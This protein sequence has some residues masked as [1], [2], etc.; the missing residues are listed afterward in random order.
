MARAVVSLTMET[1]PARQ[2]E[3]CEGSCCVAEIS[4]VRHKIGPSHDAICD[5]HVVDHSI[6]VRDVNVCIGLVRYELASRIEIGRVLCCRASVTVTT[7]Y[8]IR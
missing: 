2:R 6:T 8:G 5:G 4:T 7:G 1:S 3:Q